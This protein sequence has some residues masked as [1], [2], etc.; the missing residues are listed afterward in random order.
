LDIPSAAGIQDV[1]KHLAND[2]GRTQVIAEEIKW[3]FEQGRKV[4]VLTERTE[5]LDA[6]LQALEG[7]P[8]PFVLH[9]RMSK[10]LRSK[11]IAELNDLP[12]DSPRI[13]L[14][15]GKLVGE[16]FDHPALDTLI[17]AMPVSWK[18]TLQQYA[19]RL[20]RDHAT[21]TDVRIIDIVDTGHPALI[22][23]WEK[24][25]AGYKVMGYRIAEGVMKQPGHY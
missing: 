23:M 10:K 6:I 20:H 1:F 25:Q 18:G 22:R 2:Q 13:L 4:L 24:R 11:L 21:K 14:A 3:S 5:H 9:G 19:G 7:V 17:L 8:T 15:T 16:G 12:E